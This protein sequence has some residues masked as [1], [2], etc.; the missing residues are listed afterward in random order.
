MFVSMFVFYCASCV[1]FAMLRAGTLVR[2]FSHSFIHSFIHMNMRD[3]LD[4]EE[5]FPFDGAA[6]VGA[7][8]REHCLVFILD[9]LNDEPRVKVVVAIAM[10]SRRDVSA[11]H[12]P[13]HPRLRTSQTITQGKL[14]KKTLKTGHLCSVNSH[15]RRSGMARVNEK[16][17]SFTCHP[18]VY[19]RME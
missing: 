17:H 11:V 1:C 2:W 16:P 13:R 8:T 3:T 18:L 4:V 15:L 7:A 14:K 19:P 5:D 10:S 12:Q 9:V 6:V